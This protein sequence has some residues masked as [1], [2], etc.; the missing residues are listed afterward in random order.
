MEGEEQVRE[1]RAPAMWHPLSSEK[2]LVCTTVTTTIVVTPSAGL[3][4]PRRLPTLALRLDPTSL[5][6]VVAHG[7]T[8]DERAVPL[9]APKCRKG[10]IVEGRWAAMEPVVTT[11]TRR[12][13]KTLSSTRN[14]APAVW[15]RTRSLTHVR[16]FI[17]AVAHKLPHAEGQPC[18][19]S[20]SPM[21]PWLLTSPG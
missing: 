1:K 21:L 12:R 20:D 19:V 15:R 18:Q 10:D 14:R 2:G 13:S 8:V 4:R 9:A 17:A 11:V 3:R 16:L 7:C 6:A 5:C